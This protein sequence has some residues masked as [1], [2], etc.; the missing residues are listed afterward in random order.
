MKA[1]ISVSPTLSSTPP[2][3]FGER[4][5]GVDAE[6]EVDG[7]CSPSTSLRL[8]LPVIVPPIAAVQHPTTSAVDLHDGH[9]RHGVGAVSLAEPLLD[10]GALVGQAR[11]RDHGVLHHLQADRAHELVRD[12]GQVQ[13]DWVRSGLHKY[14]LCM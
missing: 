2:P 6:V 13:P 12:A 8:P 9:V 1:L 14:V 3:S 11:R 5:C 10:A 7:L 4:R